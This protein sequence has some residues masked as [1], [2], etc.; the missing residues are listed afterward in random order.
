MK[1]LNY[2]FLK[3]WEKNN[4]KKRI[5]KKFKILKK[6]KLTIFK[7]IKIDRNSIKKSYYIVYI[8]SVI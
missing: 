3:N 6:L 7:N 5:D 4:N 8:L 2:E 1:I